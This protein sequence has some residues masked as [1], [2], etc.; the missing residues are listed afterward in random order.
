MSGGGRMSENTG[1]DGVP[2][3]GLKKFEFEIQNCIK[4]VINHHSRDEARIHLIDNLD[5][6][7]DDMVYDCYVSDGEEIK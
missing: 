4:V 2:E 3:K 1:G 6:Y 5:A 7:A